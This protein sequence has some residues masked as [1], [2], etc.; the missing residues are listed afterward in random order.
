MLRLPWGW[1]TGELGPNE[2]RTYGDAANPD[3]SE[4]HNADVE[5]ICRKYLELRYR[6]MPYL[7][8][9]VREGCQTGLPVMRALWLHHPDD[10]DGGRAGRRVPLGPEHP[11]RA[12]DRERCDGP[13]TSTCPAASGTTSG[14]VKPVEGGREIKPRRRPGDHAAVRPRRHDPAAGPGQAIHRRSRRW[15]ADAPHLPRR[16][17]PIPGLRG[18]RRLVRLSQRR[19]DGHRPRAGTT[20]PGDL[21]I[22]LA[23]GSRM[24]PPLERRLEVRLMPDG[25]PTPVVFTGEAARSDA[26]RS[27]FSLTIAPATWSLSPCSPRS[28]WAFCLFVFLPA[29]ALRRNATLS[30][31]F[32]ARGISGAMEHRLR[33]DRR[34]RRCH[35]SGAPKTNGFL[36]PRQTNEFYYLCGIETPHAYLILDG[37]DRKATLVLPP[38]DARLESAEG[39]VISAD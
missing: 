33:P 24:R 6:L 23:E 18:R 35:H 5:P 21:S 22:S 15:P 7:Y 2:I 28:T 11:G 12:R 38:R 29:P 26:G 27:G 3:P 32:P 13:A 4:L 14:P 31:R 36:V 19:L 16:R 17:R 10:A 20:G 8:S 37:K 9:V 30:D 34:P 25:K 39:K 1:N